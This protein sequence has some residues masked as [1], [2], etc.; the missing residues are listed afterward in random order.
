MPLDAM[1]L[2]GYWSPV[3]GGRLTKMVMSRLVCVLMFA[4]SPY[5]SWIVSTN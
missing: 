4:P 5:D 1:L 3:V 2:G